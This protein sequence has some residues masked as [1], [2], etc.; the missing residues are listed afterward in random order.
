MVPSAVQLNRI[1]EAVTIDQAKT[2]L[3][4]NIYLNKINRVNITDLVVLQKSNINHQRKIEY[5]RIICLREQ[6]EPMT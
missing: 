4:F 5:P 6:T 2:V 3:W 1:T